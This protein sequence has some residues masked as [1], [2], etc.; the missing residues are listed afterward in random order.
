MDVAGGSQQAA[1]SGRAAAAES[2]YNVL[3]GQCSFPGDTLC[4]SRCNGALSWRAGQ[5]SLN[6]RPA[7]GPAGQ[8]SFTGTSSPVDVRHSSALPCPPLMN[9]R[10]HTYAAF[11]TPVSPMPVMQSPLH[12]PVHVLRSLAAIL[13]RTCASCICCCHSPLCRCWSRPDC[14]GA[15]LTLA[16]VC[17]YRIWYSEP[18]DGCTLTMCVPPFS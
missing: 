11:P 1:G 17:N 7:A 5:S 2:A 18:P 4:C 8:N 6:W 9:Q 14:W 16:S 3:S 10:S 13:C 15:F 12:C